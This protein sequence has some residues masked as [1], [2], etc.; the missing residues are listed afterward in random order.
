[1]VE[2]QLERFDCVFRFNRIL[3]A[4]SIIGWEIKATDL[5][6]QSI[7]SF[8]FMFALL[9]LCLERRLSEQFL[10]SYFSPHPFRRPLTAMIILNKIVCHLTLNLLFGSERF[11]Q[12]KPSNGSI[13]WLCRTLLP[14]E[15]NY[16]QQ[17]LSRSLSAAT[18]WLLTPLAG[19]SCYSHLSILGWSLSMCIT[20]TT[21]FA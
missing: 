10:F 13:Q 18:G 16:R 21:Y 2:P 9:Y 11:F 15:G 3:R 17:Y 4:T 19:L 12:A 5:D 7:H 1:M 6:F 8:E 20:H 14:G